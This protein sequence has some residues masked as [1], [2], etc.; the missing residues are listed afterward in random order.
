M[1]CQVLEVDTS[2]QVIQSFG[3]A[4][5]SDTTTQLKWPWYVVIDEATDECLVADRNNFRVLHLG[6]DLRP[7]DVVINSPQGPSRLCLARDR[8]LVAQS[9]HVDIFKLR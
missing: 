3:G 2:G 6:P 9:S 5:G 1:Y 7:S 8:L 4:R